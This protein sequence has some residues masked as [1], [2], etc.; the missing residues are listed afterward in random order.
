MRPC[1]RGDHPEKLAIAEKLISIQDEQFAQ[2]KPG[3]KANAIDEIVRRGLMGASLRGSYP[4]ITGYTVGYFPLS[5]PRTSD[6]TRVFQ[7]DSEWVLEAGMTFHMYVSASGLAFSETVL[8][9][10]DGMERLT[11]APRK[12]HLI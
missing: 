7:P 3:V 11:R 6:F 1:I 10:S 4:N 8:I 5:T 9:T 2:M 12:A